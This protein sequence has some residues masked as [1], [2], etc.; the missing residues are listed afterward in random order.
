MWNWQK[1]WKNVCNAKF[2]DCC[3]ET[4]L[5]RSVQGE[6]VKRNELIL[7]FYS[8]LL[9][10]CKNHIYMI[11]FYWFGDTHGKNPGNIYV[12]EIKFNSTVFGSGAPIG[13][14]LVRQK[15]CQ[16]HSLS[17]SSFFFYLLLYLSG[18]KEKTRDFLKFI[19]EN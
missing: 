10:K 19:T 8:S 15:P 17:I 14:V 9:C 11:L 13:Y 18:P 12:L 4:K 16:L 5:L 1:Q 7:K 3:C 6:L 2:V